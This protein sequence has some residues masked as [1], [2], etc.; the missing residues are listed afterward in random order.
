MT[1]SIAL[2]ANDDIGTVRGLIQFKTGI[3]ACVQNCRTAMLA[4]QGEMIYAMDSGLPTRATVWDNYN[5]Q[6]FEAA[7][8]SVLKSVQDVTGILSFTQ[9]LNNG[10]LGYSVEISTIYGNTTVAGGIV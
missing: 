4:Q 6:L 5:P 7:A 10:T 3:D 2:L 1:Q 9:S 8:R